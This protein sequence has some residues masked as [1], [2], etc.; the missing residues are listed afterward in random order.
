MGLLWAA[1]QMPSKLP[2][3]ALEDFVKG[4]R[5]HVSK[6]YK[7]WVIFTSAT[8][9]LGRKRQRTLLAEEPDLDPNSD[10]YYTVNMWR[11]G[12]I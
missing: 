11:A 5:S 4:R 8:N 10:S 1:C 2:K 6:R 9:P 7:N 12:A 3:I